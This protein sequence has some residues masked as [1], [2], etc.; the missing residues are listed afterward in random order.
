[1]L[2]FFY[3]ELSEEGILRCVP[4]QDVNVAANPCMATLCP[5]DAQQILNKKGNGSISTG[6]LLRK[7]TT[8][9]LISGH[10]DV[11]WKQK[12]ACLSHLSLIGE[13]SNVHLKALQKWNAKQRKQKKTISTLNNVF[14]A[15]ITDL[16]MGSAARHFETLLSC[17][18]LCGADIGNIGHSRKLF[19]DI[20]YCLDKAVNE[21]T[22]AW[23]NTPLPSTSMQPHFWA[24]VDKGTPSRV[25]NQAILIIARDASGTPCLIPVGS[26]DVY[27]NL[28]AS[29]GALAE[30]ITETISKN[31]GNNV[32]TR[33]VGVSADGPYQTPSFREKLMGLLGIVDK[34][35]ENQIVF[36]VTWDGGHNV[37][38]G[39]TD[40]RDAE[41]L[42]ATHL[43]RFIKRCNIFNTLLARG[44]GYAFLTATGENFLTPISFATQRFASS[45]FKQWMKIEKSYGAYWRAFDA[46]NVIRAEEEEYQYM[47]GGFDFVLDMLATL[48]TMEP[49]VDLMLR[50]QSLD[51]PIWKLKLWWPQVKSAME[52]SSA[53]GVFPR[54]EKA[55]KGGKLVPGTMYQGVQLLEG[56]LVQSSEGKGKE[57]SYSWVEREDE[58]V[59]DDHVRLAK[60]LVESVENRMN[61]TLSSK[62]LKTLEVFDTAALVSLHCGSRDNKL[63]SD[64][65]YEEYGV[66]E[67]RVV[68]EAMCQHRHIQNSGMDFDPKLAHRYILKIKDA[69]G[70]GIWGGH[71]KNWFRDKTNEPLE[72]DSQIKRFDKDDSEFSFEAAFWLE[73]DDGKSGR[74]QLHEQSVYASLYAQKEVYTLAGP[75]GCTII[76]YVLSKGG[77]EAIA[78]SYYSTMRSQ[79]QSGGQQNDTLEKRTKLSWCLPSLKNC[80][81]LINQATQT[82]LSGDESIKAHRINTFFSGRAKK[83]YDVSKVVDRVDGELGRCP[84]LAHDDE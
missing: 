21:Q 33:L 53:H 51:G 10:N 50:L 76:D 30:M 2:E 35:P 65:D 37:N 16:K 32:L 13:G 19:P 62:H 42:S 45:S 46:A 47:I 22:A 26:P 27:S 63:M 38:L 12:H 61:E 14:R 48:D 1:M 79:Q 75:Q 66:S 44:K 84:F 23:L 11:W 17:L 67:C 25:T 68:L 59:R 54:I 57:K 29:Y 78:E 15:A 8:R 43:N 55:E 58:E 5:R 49:I 77:P 80:Q 24:T 18:A 70:A 31:F 69:V 6:L 34:D 56:W 4:C 20:L 41:S 72:N 71:C 73:F 7:A 60:D 9:Q 3:D 52:S 39:I 28:D 81:Q 36:P 82:Y 64:G 83:S 40:I 74:F